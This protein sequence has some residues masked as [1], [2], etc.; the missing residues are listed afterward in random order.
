MAD[1]MQTI[2]PR[3][4]ASLAA[5]TRLT[6][7][8]YD[9]VNVSMLSNCFPP[10]SQLEYISE[11]MGSVLPTELLELVL[12]YCPNAGVMRVLNAR[13][14]ALH[15]IASQTLVKRWAGRLALNSEAAEKEGTQAASAASSIC[16][17]RHRGPTDFH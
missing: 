17:V 2:V 14:K 6:R 5:V 7:L 12:R 9:G 15:D 13:N 4:H 1:C 11:A 10:L 16:E 8:T 3:F